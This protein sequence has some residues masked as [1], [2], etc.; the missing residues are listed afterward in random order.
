MCQVIC[1]YEGN[2]MQTTK[3]GFI[4]SENVN[5]VINLPVPLTGMGGLYRRVRD[6]SVNYF[7]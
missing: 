7:D 3:Y 4:W 5:F 6:F 2:A 1:T